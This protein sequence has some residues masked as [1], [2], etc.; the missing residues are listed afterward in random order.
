VEHENPA[1]GWRSLVLQRVIEAEFLPVR[2][3]GGLRCTRF[4]AS[5][6]PF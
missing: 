3:P 5:G 6:N 1:A 2:Q 4:A